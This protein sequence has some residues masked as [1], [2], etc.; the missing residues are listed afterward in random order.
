MNHGFESGLQ[1]WETYV[2]PSISRFAAIDS[3]TGDVARTGNGAVRMR[4][5]A[6]AAD[7]QTEYISLGQSVALEPANRYRYSVHVR[8]A[9]PENALPSAIVSAWCRNADGSYNGVDHWITEADAAAA[10]GGYVP[11]AFDFTPNSTE[12]V[13]CYIAL[14]THQDGNTDATEIV[15]DDL[16]V[17]ASGAASL[18]ADTRSGNLLGNGS[19][20]SGTGAQAGPP[21]QRTEWN[22]LTVTGLVNEVTD[23]EDRRLHLALPASQNPDRLN[24]TWTGQYQTVRLNAGVAYELSA[25]IDRQVPAHAA[26]TIVNIYAYKP[27]TSTPQAWLGSVDYTFTRTDSHRYVQTL[28]PAETSDY[29]I[30]VRVFGWGNGGT[31]VD[32][33]VDDVELRV[34][35]S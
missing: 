6:E 4:L 14:L 25:E 22:P 16:T 33:L 17:T 26:P 21:W 27:E 30:T 29:Q 7:N 23:G 5:P 24:E 10:P 3:V 9:N 31:P 12:E 19:F 1:G 15:V 28:I 8:W 32:V 18:E 35:G 2:A 11:I 20:E 34:A 13:F